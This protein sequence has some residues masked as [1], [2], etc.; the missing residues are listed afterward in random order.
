SSCLAGCRGHFLA[1][2]SSLNTG[3]ANQKHVPDTLP[4]NTSPPPPRKTA[5]VVTTITRLPCHDQRTARAPR[6]RA[7]AC[8]RRRC[9][10]RL[11]SPDRKRTRHG[12]RKPAAT[13]AG[14][15]RSHSRGGQGRTRPHR[16][17][18]ELVVGG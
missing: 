7:P 15:A 13:R 10:G 11:V 16:R 3:S 18:A 5:T 2:G 14:A 4:D 9:A 17:G 8:R 6:A 12:G 1:H